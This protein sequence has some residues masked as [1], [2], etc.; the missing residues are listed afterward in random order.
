MAKSQTELVNRALAKIGAVGS[1]QTASA[2]DV[3]IA[4]DALTPLV[5]ELNSLGV[6]YVPLSS[7]TA[8]EVIEDR[9]FQGLATLLSMDIAAEFGV[10]APSDAMRQDAMN[11]LRRITA[12]SPTYEVLRAD[13]F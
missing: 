1:G 12:A 6:C 8:E 2:E 5:E 4:T 13:Y 9:L 3:T 7:D 10:A 11:V